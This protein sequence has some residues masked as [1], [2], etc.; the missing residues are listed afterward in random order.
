MSS[1]AR[2]LLSTPE[3]AR[4]LRVSTKFLTNRRWA[5]GGP[6]FI[7]LGR[8]VVY[9]ETDLNAWVDAGRR[10]STSQ[11]EAQARA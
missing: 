1:P 8:K 2:T 4:F 9:D 5:G 3:A 6:R 7:R 11:T 10:D